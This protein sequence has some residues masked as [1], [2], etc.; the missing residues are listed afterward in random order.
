MRRWKTNRRKS[1]RRKIALPRIRVE[2]KWF[3]LPPAAV[4][5]LVV[6][7]IGVQSALT[8]PVRALKLEGVFQRVT[9]LQI[10]AAAVEALN[11]GFLALDLTRV[12][13]GIETLAWIDSA[14]VT[15]VWPDTLAIRVIEQQAAAR[16]GETGLLNTRGELF[17]DDRRYGLP[18]LPVLS[19]PAGS[20]RVVAER[21]LYLRERLKRASLE[22]EGLLMDDRGAWQLR[23]ASG[24]EIRLG[25]DAVPA[26]LERF[27]TVVVPA[28]K[29]ELRR[30]AT[31][32]MR[33]TNGF[34]IAWIGELELSYADT[35][36]VAGSG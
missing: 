36:E 26:R 29:G 20:E 25:N 15:R 10:E 13:R 5:T 9:P 14:E 33:Y 12:Q 2:L 19:G 30:A 27:F 34:A 22:L 35:R 23:L 6:T 17:S 11:R 1:P 3:V 18:E 21:Y 7:F 24:Q 32:D 16:W 28:L 31:I 8:L 4:A